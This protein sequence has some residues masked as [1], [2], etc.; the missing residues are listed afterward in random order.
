MEVSYSKDTPSNQPPCKMWW[1]QIPGKSFILIY[2]TF[3][4]EKL[5][6]YPLLPLIPPWNIKVK[7]RRDIIGIHILNISYTKTF[8]DE[9]HISNFID[10][11]HSPL[12]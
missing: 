9:S 12:A 1:I 4:F 8:M 5:K 6:A 10:I 11:Y 2:K 3:I 7:A